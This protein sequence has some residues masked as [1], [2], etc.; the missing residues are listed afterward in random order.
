MSLPPWPQIDHGSFGPIDG[1]EPLPK[2]RRIA[3][4][5]LS[6]NWQTIPHVTHHDDADVTTLDV[7]RRGLR[8]AS[9][10]APS[11]LP[12]VVKAVAAALSEF[13]QFNVSLDASGQSL[14]RK[15]YFHVGIAIDTP[16]G[17]LVG[18]IRDCDRKQPLELAAEIEELAARAKDRGLP[19]ADMLGG[20]ITVSSLGHIGGT[21]FTPIINAPEAAI[22]GLGR[23][24]PV[25]TPGPE[26]AVDWRLALP[27]SLSYDHRLLDGSDAARFCVALS[28]HLSA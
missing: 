3:G 17:L 7:R 19:L 5:L 2:L 27:L 28:K 1:P 14:I 16:A 8:L 23:A 13:P 21:Y 4:P 6:R 9:G 10:R 26:G 20:C 25:A 18:V 15:R 11:L 12:F 22:L 24:R